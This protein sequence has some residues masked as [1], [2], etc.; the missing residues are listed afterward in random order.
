MTIVSPSSCAFPTGLFIGF[1]QPS[2]TFDEPKLNIKIVD[3]ALVTS[4]ESERQFVTEIAL[5][6]GTA[7]QDVGAGGD[8]TFAVERV[9]FDP[10]VRN[11]SVQLEINPDSIFEGTESFQIRAISSQDGPAY[12]CVDPCI[13]LTTIFIVDD[14]RKYSAFQW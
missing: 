14:N 1:E 12:D 6:Q 9:I 4:I 11:Q 13:A 3:V 2:Y 7:T 10:G 5:V 8:Y